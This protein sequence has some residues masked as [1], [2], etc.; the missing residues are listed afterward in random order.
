MSSENKNRIEVQ[1]ALIATIGR[2]LRSFS[3]LDGW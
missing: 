1:D 3:T 2:A